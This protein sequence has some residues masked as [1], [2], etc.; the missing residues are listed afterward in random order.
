MFE[1]TVSWHPKRG[2]TLETSKRR[3][4]SETKPKKTTINKGGGLP[5]VDQ[6]RCYLFYFVS[7]FFLYS[8]IMVAIATTITISL[9]YDLFSTHPHK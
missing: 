1:I 7:V 9:Y 4:G 8:F 2:T 3:Q 5:N 6:Q